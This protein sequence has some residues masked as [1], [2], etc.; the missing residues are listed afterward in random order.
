MHMVFQI[1]NLLLRQQKRCVLLQGNLHFGFLVQVL[2]GQVYLQ[3][4]SWLVLLLMRW[5]ELLGGRVV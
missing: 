4:Q 1:Y 3:Y 2:L 5:Q